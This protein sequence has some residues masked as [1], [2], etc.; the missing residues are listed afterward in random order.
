MRNSNPK[1]CKK[2]ANGL[3]DVLDVRDRPPEF[4]VGAIL[5]FVSF[6]Q[7]LVDEVAWV[8]VFSE[9]P[10]K[11]LGFGNLVFR[12]TAMRFNTPK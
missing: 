3:G 1:W 12:F 8:T 11:I 9:N 2:A 6:A 10:S 4:G 7:A 5:S